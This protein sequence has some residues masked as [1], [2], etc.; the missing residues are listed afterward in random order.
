MVEHYSRGGEEQE[1]SP[2]RE[3]VILCS[4]SSENTCE[5]P[6]KWQ[7]WV[8]REL[9]ESLRTKNDEKME[10]DKGAGGTAAPNMMAVSVAAS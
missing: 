9:R 7:I 3:L 6:R 10:S 8:Q 2:K 1:R 4:T 5:K